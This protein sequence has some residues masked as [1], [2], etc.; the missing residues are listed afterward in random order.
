MAYGLYDQAADLVR[1]ESGCAEAG[2]VPSRSVFLHR[3]LYEAHPGVEAIIIAHPPSAMVFTVTDAAFDSRTIPE[4][5][6]LLR[7]MPKLPYGT[8]FTD[9]D[10]TVAAFSPKVPVVLTEND[11]LMVT[12]SSLLNAFDRLEVAEYSAKALIAAQGLGK[13][14]VINDEQ[15]DD[16]IAAFKLEK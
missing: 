2:K 5:F 11:S 14:V 16:L 3:K 7:S 9:L 13:V 12:G 15:V 6:I 10:R 1:I 8:N 4:S